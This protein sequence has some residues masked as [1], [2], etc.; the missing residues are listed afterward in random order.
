MIL[1]DCFFTTQFEFEFELEPPPEL[2]FLF[3]PPNGSRP[4]DL[5][6]KDTDMWNW[7]LLITKKSRTP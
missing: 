5:I 4:S 7:E 6:E 3:L 2:G 1:T